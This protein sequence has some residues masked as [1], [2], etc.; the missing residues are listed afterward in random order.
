MDSPGHRVNN[1]AEDV[2]V[3]GL[4]LVVRPGTTFTYYW[5]LAFGSVDDSEATPPAVVTPT[6]TD[7]AVSVTGTVPT[8]GVAL[9]Q[10]SASGSAEGIVAGLSQRGCRAASVWLVTSGSL[11][12]YLAGAPGFV[13]AAFPASVAAGT[14]F[15]AV[16]R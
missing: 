6:A 12:G 1:L 9:L 16:C 5:A 13:N 7:A 14:P 15:L 8:V 2:K 10:T 3:V 4:A 11:R